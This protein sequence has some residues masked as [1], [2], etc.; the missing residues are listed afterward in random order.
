MK[1][2]AAL[3]QLP[4][5]KVSLSTFLLIGFDLEDSQ[6]VYHTSVFHIVFLTYVDI[7]SV[8]KLAK[9]K[10]YGQVSSSQISK[11]SE[12]CCTVSSITGAKFSWSMFLTSPPLF[13]KPNLLLTLQLRVCQCHYHQKPWLR[14]FPC[15]FHHHC[16][17][18]FV[19]SWN[20]RK[21]V[22]LNNDYTNPKRMMPWPRSDVSAA[23]PK[24]SG[25]SSSLM[26]PELEIG[27]TRA[28]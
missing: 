23:L 6:L 22:T 28:W 19:L 17:H 11:I 1:E 16:R 18:M 7:F 24:D 3:G 21:F 8:A 25:C 13:R 9:W 2:E 4:R 26:Y 12:M 15:S 5:H 27:Q 20:S 10:G 14:T